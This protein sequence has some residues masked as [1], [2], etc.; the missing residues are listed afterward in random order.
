LDFPLPLALRS[1]GFDFAV[2]LVVEEEV[3]SVG[4]GLEV[5][6]LVDLEAELLDLKLMMDRSL[7]SY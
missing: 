1:V 6:D 7:G 4:M 3:G 5:L 2:E